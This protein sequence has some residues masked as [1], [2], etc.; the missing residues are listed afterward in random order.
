VVNANIPLKNILP[1]G[2]RQKQGKSEHLA[3]LKKNPTSDAKTKFFDSDIRSRI[4]GIAFPLIKTQEKNRQV[5]LI[6]S[7]SY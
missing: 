3:Y 4:F 7:E 5:F 2:F 6:S 1:F